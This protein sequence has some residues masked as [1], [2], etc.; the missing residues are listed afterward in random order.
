MERGIGEHHP[1]QRVLGR[2]LRR[3]DP[4]HPL[5]GEEYDGPLHRLEQLRLGP[6]HRGQGAR[7]AKL[8]DHHRERLRIAMLASAEQLDRLR[9]GRVAGEV[10]A[11]EPL[12]RNDVARSERRSRLTERICGGQVPPAGVEEPELGPT[13]RAGIGLC[14]E[15]PVAGIVVLALA[16]LAHEEASHG[17]DSTVVGRIESDGEAR[18]AVGAVGERVPVAA[19]R[20]I[21][22]L[23]D[24]R[25]AGG[26]VGGD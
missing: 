1:D 16:G 17:S 5:A 8:P 2:D 20:G 10:V 6:G 23:R 12:H 9:G 24:A 25:S 18:T 15:A 14:V 22:D 11:A 4:P 13:A 3:Q 7:V 21:E 26:K 19:V